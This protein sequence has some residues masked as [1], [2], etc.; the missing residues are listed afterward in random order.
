[1]RKRAI[2]A[3]GLL[4][5]GFAVALLA[6]AAAPD[7]LDPVAGLLLLASAGVALS[8]LPVW[9]RLR[10]PPM[11]GLFERP[12]PGERW[13]P[14]CGR[15]APPGACPRCRTEG[16]RTRRARRLQRKRSPPAQ[17]KKP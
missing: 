5:A 12:A 4:A 14:V 7:A 2:V 11:P 1:M 16:R 6:R 8:L 9:R 13:C 10:G 17:E 15:P 3:G